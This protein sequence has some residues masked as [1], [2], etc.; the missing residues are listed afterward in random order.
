MPLQLNPVKSSVTLLLTEPSGESKGGLDVN[1]SSK[2]EM[3]SSLRSA[4]L[5]GGTVLRSRT[6]FQ[7]TEEKKRWDFTSS[8]SFSPYPS[9]HSTYKRGIQIPMHCSLV[10]NTLYSEQFTIVVDFKQA[11]LFICIVYLSVKELREDVFRVRS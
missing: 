2:L 8:A 6:A 5:K 1:S 10:Q 11:R 4:G 9:R 3:S 7:S